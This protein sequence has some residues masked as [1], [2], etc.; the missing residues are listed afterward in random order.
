MKKF[1]EFENKLL[2]FVVAS[3]EIYFDKA[4]EG[5]KLI[6][7]SVGDEIKTIIFQRNPFRT[8]IFLFYVI[9]QATTVNN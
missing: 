3:F 5:Y 9:N 6:L 4:F 2:I 1:I 7:I 8:L